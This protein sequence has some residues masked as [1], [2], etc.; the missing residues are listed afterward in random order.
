MREWYDVKVR[1]TLELHALIDF[2]F[3]EHPDGP[4][5]GVQGRQDTPA[6][7]IAS[8]RIERGVKHGQHLVCETE[9]VDSQED[10]ELLET[11]SATK[12]TG[13]AATLKNMNMDMSDVQWYR[14][15]C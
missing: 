5:T 10:D 14:S 15:C 9:E 6:S 7:T 1:G 3:G 4:I 12:F 13:L 8:T 11:R 2:F